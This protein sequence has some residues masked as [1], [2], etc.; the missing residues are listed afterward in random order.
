MQPVVVIAEQISS[1]G[2]ALLA[3]HCTVVDVIGRPRADVL[4]AVESAQALIVRSATDVDADMIAAGPH[5]KV[6]GRAGIGVDNID[7]AAATE[8]GVMVVNAPTANIVSAAEHTLALLLSQARN[9]PAADSK[10]RAGVWD[11]K[12]F[13]GVELHGKTLGVLGLGRIGTLVAERAQAFG[14]T[15]IAYDPYVNPDIAR[16]SG[17]EM[18]DDLSE[19]LSQAD[20]LTIHLPK[21]RETEGLIGKEALASVKP[22][23]RIFNASRGGIVDEHALAE[24]VRSGMV[25]GAGL[26]VYESE[27]LTDSPLFELPEV[28]LT[29]HLGASTAEAQDKAGR[30]VAASVLAALR[31]DLVPSAVNVDIGRDVS[32]AVRVFLP[33]VEGIARVF[34]SL[35]KGLPKTFTVAAEG[36]IGEHPTRPL[37]LAALRGALSMVSAEPVTYVNAES[38]AE[39]HGVRVVESSTTESPDWLS[40]VR[41]MGTVDGQ[42][43]TVSGTL[44]R[45]GAMIVELQGNDVELPLSPNMLLIRNDDEP[46]IIGRVG[47]FL[48]E[49]RV[50]IAN[51]VVGRSRDTGQPA[52]MG[53]DIDQP[54]TDDDLLALRALDGVITARFVTI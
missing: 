6:V 14:M 9:V 18:L 13:K 34:V 35:A 50:N 38:M 51:M 28:V 48:G 46:G 33:M 31:G 36:R 22:G 49:R 47:T 4:D 23:I 19:I 1:A 39:R 54:L 41:L 17:V 12:S 11:R 15:V 7:L 3:D 42:D 53:I 29:P 24:S 27:P 16:R 30:D 25:A 40:V 2:L 21:T 44:A 20:F 52:M 45:K 8:A 37:T 5:L 10:M 26:D 32:E 43:V